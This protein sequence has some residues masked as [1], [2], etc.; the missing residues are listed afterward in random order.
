M[1]VTNITYDDKVKSVDL[2]NP[3]AQKVQASD[4]NEIKTVVNNNGNELSTAQS[5]I[6][7]N[8]SALALKENL[9]AKNTANGYAG[10]DG[11]TLVPLSLL[12]DSVK[13]GSEYKGS[14][15]ANTNTPALA[16]GSGTNGD[17]YLV[18]TA[19]SQDLG[20]GTIV[21]EVGDT[22]IYNGTT[23]V[24]GK[25]GRADLVQSVNGLQ[26]VVVLTESDIPSIAATYLAL[27][28]GTMTGAILGDQ[29]IRAYRPMGAEIDS[30]FNVSSATQNSYNTINSASSPVTI[31][32]GDADNASAAIGWEWEFFVSS[33]ANT[34]MFAV[35]GSQSI[36]SKG[37][38]LE[39]TELGVACVLKKVANNTWHL[40]G[41]Q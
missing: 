20:S 28:G 35:S 39:L 34:I 8:T 9:S 2:P 5:D 3:A 32:V 29:S 25:I 37:S 10:L 41:A 33:Y 30:S 14:W 6:S 40:I 15:N 24:W 23:G 13:S 26:G 31:A 1:A 4:L 17:F 7:S 22:V 19:G 18:D 27:S 11:S 36:I 38:Q 16:D 12:P 21:F